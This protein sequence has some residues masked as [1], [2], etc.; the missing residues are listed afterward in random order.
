M[1]GG[2]HLDPREHAGR[3][4]GL[5]EAQLKGDIRYSDTRERGTLDDV[6]DMRRPEGELCWHVVSE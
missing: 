1:T 3:E 2:A 4:S 5:R 6:L